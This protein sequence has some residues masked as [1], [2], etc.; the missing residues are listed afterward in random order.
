[1]PENKLDYDDI[2]DINSVITSC[3]IIT[4]LNRFII[5]FLF[6]IYRNQKCVSNN[7]SIEPHCPKVKIHCV[8]QLSRSILLFLNF[9]TN[10]YPSQIR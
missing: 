8:A 4:V 6:I 10:K 5:E 9:N 2:T 3:L 1:L 7:N